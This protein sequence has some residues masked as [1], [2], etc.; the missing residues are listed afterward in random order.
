MVRVHFTLVVALLFAGSSHVVAAHPVGHHGCAHEHTQQRT[1]GERDSGYFFNRRV[2]YLDEAENRPHGRHLQTTTTWA[3][4]RVSVQ[5]VS[6]AGAGAL[7]SWLK[8]TLLP[9]ALTY[10]QETLQVSPVSGTLK[11]AR[12]CSSTYVSSGTCKTQGPIPT[13]GIE[14]NGADHIVEGTLLDSLETCTTCYTNGNPCSGCSTAPAG[15]G[16]AADYILFVSSVNTAACGGGTLAYASTCQRDQK[17][18]PIVGYANFCPNALSSASA[19]WVTQK[20][21][22]VHELLH[23]LGFSSGSWP[24]FRNGD[25][26]PMTPREADGLPEQKAAGSVTC[27]DGNPS[28]ATEYA[29]SASTLEV[30]TERGTTVTR[31][32]TP[33]VVAV[34]RDIFGCATLRGP[35]LENSP[36]GSPPGCYASHWEQRNFMNELMAP[37]SSHTAVY[38]ALTLAA[39]EDSGWYKANYTASEPLLWGRNQGCS[40]VSEK[41]VGGASG[42]LAGFCTTG[43]SP[44]PPHPAGA[45]GCTPGHRSLGY[46]DLETKSSDITPAQYRYIA[47]QPRQG[48]TMPEADYCPHYRALN[49]GACDQAGNAPASN[50]RGEAYAD[51][52]QCFDSTV[53]LT[54][55]VHD[56]SVVQGCYKSRCQAGTF[57]VGVTLGDGTIEWLSCT[58]AASQQVSGTSAAWS[59]GVNGGKVHCPATSALLCNPHACPGLPCDGNAQQCFGGVCVCGT[60][61]GTT[62]HNG[63]MP[64][65]PPPAPLPPMSPGA[66]VKSVVRFSMTCAGT[67]DTFDAA[68]FKAK[69]ATFLG[70]G[71]TED[72]I[73]LTVTAASVVVAVQ[74]VA[75]TASVASAV[76]ST[77]A[78]ATASSLTA[79]LEVTVTAVTA[80]STTLQVIAAPAPPPPAVPPMPPPPLNSMTLIIALAGGVVVC[81]GIG[82]AMWFFLCKGRG[83]VTHGQTV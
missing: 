79:A 9:A 10:V 56:G 28:S 77:V 63:T 12:F 8:D 2:P 46:C 19:Q 49:G 38:S 52:S 24:L 55:W 16:V 64:D 18:R 61:W 32:L 23:A 45:Y 75:P 69:L 83:K 5:Y 82:V 54:G 76:S 29:I 57:Q 65:S 40:F 3:N 58:G 37:I 20:S 4:L 72:E 78:T 7:E 43:L 62:C 74:V 26:T 6:T 66:A 42:T 68:A 39:L 59:S 14:A 35:E 48:G 53:V 15:A 33:R 71:I 36:T 31:L 41:C 51:G 21:T 67:V 73:K 44:S 70:N 47:G 25:G 17:D 13:C 27:T 34:A 80:P 11:V 60:P 81:V 1:G 22:A 30:A 50:T